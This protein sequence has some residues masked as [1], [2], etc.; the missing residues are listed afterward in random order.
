MAFL[1]ASFQEAHVFKFEKNYK[2]KKLPVAI[3][4]GGPV[5]LAAAAHLA[6]RN[7]YFILLEAGDNVAA[8]VLNW[9]HVKLFSP[10][11]YNIDK[12]AAELLRQSGWIAPDEDTLPTGD[13]LYAQYLSPLAE[14]RAIKPFIYTNSKVVAIGRKGLDKMKTSGRDSMP[15]VLEV[16]QHLR[17]RTFEAR[18]V[19]DATGTW[20]SHNPLGSGGIDAPG[21]RENRSRIFYGIPDVLNKHKERFRSRSIAV[22][23][24]GHSAINTILDLVGLKEKYPATQ[25][26][27]ILR[28]QNIRDVYGGQ[29]N[30]ALPARGELGEK[31]EQLILNEVV[32]V[33]TPFHIESIIHTGTG[34]KLTG[35]QLGEKRA[36]SSIDEIVA[37][38]GSR[39]DY[40]FLRE[41]RVETD[42]VVESV[43]ALAE[44][45]D[46]NVHSCG[47]VRPHGEYELRQKEKDLYVVGMKSYGR[48]PT[49]LLATGYEQVRSVVAAL[50]GD[51]EAARRTELDLPET[52]VCGTGGGEGACCGVASADKQEVVC[53]G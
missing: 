31:I 19:I 41:V 43:P 18:A 38:T 32:S 8:N 2:M 6:A 27:W 3:I 7:E 15:F 35:S 47:T 14:H 52:G 50:S 16:Q 11:K 45:I 36:L 49:F 10:W 25:I 17:T 51:H 33:Y 37:N 12:T 21:E 20:Q 24:G 26:H 53:C 9:G 29:E 22:V 42:P 28:K 23:G 46:P 39:P 48:A 40:S 34:L 4:G 13:A 1:F 5:G 44:L 30:D